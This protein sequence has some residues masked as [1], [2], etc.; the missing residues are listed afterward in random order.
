V[1]A[2]QEEGAPRLAAA[3]EKL[4]D[5]AALDTPSGRRCRMLGK[6]LQERAALEKALQRS[7]KALRW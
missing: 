2:W 6:G 4:A 3:V 7:Q 5:T 1:A